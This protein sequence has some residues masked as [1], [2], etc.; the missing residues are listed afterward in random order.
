MARWSPDLSNSIA[1]IIST[2]TS[3]N[4]IKNSRYKL[5]WLVN[6]SSHQNTYQVKWIR[7]KKHKSFRFISIKKNSPFPLNSNL[8]LILIISF[9]AVK[10][11]VSRWSILCWFYKENGKAGI[12]D[13]ESGIW[14]PKIKRGRGRNHGNCLENLKLFNLS[15]WTDCNNCSGFVHQCT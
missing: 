1:D 11:C 13:P 6:K 15:L 5:S 7:Q 3:N 12:M 14:D 2:G 9:N 10:F 8:W 4:M